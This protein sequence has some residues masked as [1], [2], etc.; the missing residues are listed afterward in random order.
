MFHHADHVHPFRDNVVG[1]ELSITIPTEY[2][3]LANTYYKVILTVTDSSGLATTVEKDVRPNL[4]TLT[5]GANNPNARYTLDGI[6][7]TGT[8]T[9]LAV[10]GVHRTIGA[11]SPQTV[12]GQQ[13]AFGSWSDGGTQTHVIVTPGANTSYTVNY[14]AVA[15]SITV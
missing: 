4:V 15:S 7:R 14:A 3:Q 1:P 12:G 9:E 11:I 8:Y 13:L 10:V 5:F 6:P 2:D